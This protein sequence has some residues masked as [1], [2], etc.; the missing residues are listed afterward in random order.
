MISESSKKKKCESSNPIKMEFV[1]L[2]SKYNI[3][4]YRSVTEFVVLIVNLTAKEP[5]QRVAH[6]PPMVAPGPTF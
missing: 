2:W 4:G 6:M 5:E 3:H 1:L